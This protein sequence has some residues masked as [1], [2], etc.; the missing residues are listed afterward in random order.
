MAL[1][2]AS[3]LLMYRLML[4]LNVNPGLALGLTIGFTVSPAVVLSENFPMYEYLMMALL[5]AATLVLYYLISKPGFWPS[6][7]L[8]SLL[9]A[10]AWIRALYHLYFLVAFAAIVVWFVRQ[11]RLAV[12]A[13]FQLC[14]CSRYSRFT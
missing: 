3:A 2:L 1:G 4:N 5:L 11:N 6:L 12:L 9:A 13:G 14:L 7:A 8:F 10:L